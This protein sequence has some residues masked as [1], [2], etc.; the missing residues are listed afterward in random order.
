[1]ERRTKAMS[2]NIMML[3]HFV[4]EVLQLLRRAVY[5]RPTTKMAMEYSSKPR[6]KSTY[7]PE[8]RLTFNDQSMHLYNQLNK[9]LGVDKRVTMSGNNYEIN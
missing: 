1:M 7:W 3:V 6:I 4:G 9:A 5:L 2:A 8:E